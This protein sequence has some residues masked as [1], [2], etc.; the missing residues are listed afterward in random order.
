VRLGAI[1]ENGWPWARWLFLS[2]LAAC[3][4]SAASEPPHASGPPPMPVEIATVKAVPL[5]D[6]TE[7]VAVLRSRQ[8][9][10]V[11]PQVPGHVT[12]IAVTSGDRVVAGRPLM[13]IDPSQQR[14]TLN[15]QL[16][17][18]EANRA[19]V[20]YARKRVERVERLAAGGAASQQDLDQAQS[21]LRQA[22]GQAASSEAQARAGGVQLRYYD[23]TAAAAGTVGDIPVRIGDYVT[24]QTLLTTLDDNDMLEAY[25]EVPVERAPQLKLG[26]PVEIVDSAGAVLA[27]SEVTFV[28]PRT[29]PISQMV[30]AKAQIDNRAGRLRVAEF[31]RARVIWSR[32]EGPAVPV[33]AVQSRAGQS[34]VWVVEQA[35]DG[36]LTAKPRAVQVG[37]IQG[38]T[39][40]VVKG[41]AP[42]DR[43]VVSGVQKLRPGAPVAPA[44]AASA[45]QAGR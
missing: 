21:S 30:L 11:Q 25:V 36:A 15:S 41:L 32:R 44:P 9:V 22:E 7:Y 28:S 2:S 33:L 5:R 24:P 1:S 6:T 14:A 17:V 35:P 29:D 10:Q 4:A 26:T 39:Y 27:P 31:V 13:Q 42:G 38:Q 45:P 3:T 12:S 19:A 37:P 18:L 34:F 8:S 16:G 23:V 43:I 40:P 20:Q